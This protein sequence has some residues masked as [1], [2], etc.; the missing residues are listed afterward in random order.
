[1]KKKV[2]YVKCPIKEI[3]VYKIIACT[4]EEAWK[5]YEDHEDIEQISSMSWDGNEADRLVEIGIAEGDDLL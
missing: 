2:Y 5:K 1:M 3:H 4:P